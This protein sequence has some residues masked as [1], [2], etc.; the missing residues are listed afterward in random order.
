MIQ[1]LNIISIQSQTYVGGK[2]AR[3]NMKLVE[4]TDIDPQRGILEQ[5]IFYLDP[6]TDKFLRVGESKAL[7][8]IMVKEAGIFQT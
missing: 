6:L 1:A 4:I 8:E 5:M 7:N 3:R 2:R